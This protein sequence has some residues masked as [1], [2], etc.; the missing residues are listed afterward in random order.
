MF[1][2]QDAESGSGGRGNGTE[3]QADYFAR[4]E[5]PILGQG[6]LYGYPVPAVQFCRALTE[7]ERN[8]APDTWRN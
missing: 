1:H 2:R 6:W 5:Q 7:E 3:E 4:C 8:A